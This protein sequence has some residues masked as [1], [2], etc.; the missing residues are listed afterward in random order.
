MS[1][2]AG[3]GRATITPPVPVSLAGFAD[4]TEPAGSVHDDLEVYA[5]WL[6]D[7][8]R[9]A[10][11]LVL[12]LLGMSVEFSGPIRDAV[13]ADHGLPSDAVLTS[14][15]H[16]H[17]GPNAM[18]GGEL[19]GWKTPEGYGRLLVERCTDAARAAKAAAV[20]VTLHHARAS[21][22]SDISYNRRSLPYEPWFAALELRAGGGA[23]VG[24]IANIAIHPVSLGSPWLAVS[25]DW[26]GPFREA[27]AETG[28]GTTVMLSGSL[29]D[30]NPVERHTDVPTH[31]AEAYEE[32][33][34]IGAAA[35]VAVHNAVT[36]AVPVTGPLRTG[37]R[38]LTVP[39]EGM[40]AQLLGIT[41]DTVE[42]VE[43]M[44]GSVHLVAIPGEAFHALGR[45]ID[46]ARGGRALLAGL[47]PAWHGYLPMPF[48]DGY[49]ETVSLGARAVSQL[50]DALVA[51]AF[52][53]EAT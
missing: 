11:L 30:V 10:C 32:A 34:A 43:W 9:A 40:L 35:A 33:S 37:S 24:V 12:D 45:A 6:A 46:D 15:T 4:R 26:V 49:E 48:G 20:P 31:L 51:G 25:R 53:R 19:L 38:T 50:A 2:R 47:A 16:T 5:V 13:A 14:S 7:G 23:R 44:L 36:A 3:I 29:G 28:G 22:P 21:L 8:E 18:A 52:A 42:L 39:A 41:E 1:W 17:S 27:L